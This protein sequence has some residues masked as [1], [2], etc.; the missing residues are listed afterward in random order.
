MTL[1]TNGFEGTT[2]WAQV[3]TSGTAGTLVARHL[4]HLP[5]LLQARRH[6]H[7][8]VQLLQ[9]GQRLR[10]A[11]LPDLRLRHRFSTYTTVTWTFW[12]YHDTGYTTNA[13]KV[14]P[15][16]STNGTT[17]TS[18]G[19]AINRYDGSTGWKQHTV[20]LTTYKGSTV[21]L[22]FLATSAYGN[23][24]YLDDALVVAQ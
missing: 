18:V 21:Q 13:D 14:Q 2:G 16:V 22:G 12:M 5:H 4:R 3:D 7:G 23:N 19:S 9:R 17:W 24:I 6:L 1:F 10:D 15:Q 20:S 11:L 8:Q